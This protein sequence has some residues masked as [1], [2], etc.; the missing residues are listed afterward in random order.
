MNAVTAI[1]FAKN[2]GTTVAPVSIPYINEFGTIH[3]F[4][5]DGNL[6][7]YGASSGNGY[8]TGVTVVFGIEELINPD[9]TAVEWREVKEDLFL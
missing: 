3:Y 9:G 6:V 7:R 1:Q 8:Q 5:K 2:T 4:Y